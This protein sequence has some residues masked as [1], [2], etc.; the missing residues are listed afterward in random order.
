MV[1]LNS[2]SENTYR[3]RV[4]VYRII[5]TIEDEILT[6]EVVKIDRRRNVYK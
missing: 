3:I 5:Y 1:A 6:V 4:G 2:G